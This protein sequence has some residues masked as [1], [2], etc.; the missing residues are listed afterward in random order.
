MGT[1]I[2][3]NNLKSTSGSG[4][5]DTPF[6]SEQDIDCAFYFDKMVPHSNEI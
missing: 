2:R 3:L 4:S 6:I 5:V 1:A